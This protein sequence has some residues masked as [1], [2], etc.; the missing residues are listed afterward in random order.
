MLLLGATAR[1]KEHNVREEVERRKVR[2]V[3]SMLG[4]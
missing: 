2:V 4:R 3:R 1:E